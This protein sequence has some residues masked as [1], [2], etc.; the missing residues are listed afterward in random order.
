MNIKT[1][2]IKADKKQISNFLMF[3][4]LIFLN[5]SIFN[6]GT[7]IIKISTNIVNGDSKD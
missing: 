6:I 3:I 2:I 4:L 7:K 1:E 5:C